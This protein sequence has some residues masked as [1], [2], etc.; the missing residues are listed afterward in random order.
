MAENYAISSGPFWVGTAMFII[1]GIIACF[2]TSRVFQPINGR[3]HQYLGLSW[4]MIS[5]T[6]FCCW[7]FWGMAW[8]MQW[9]PLITPMVDLTKETVSQ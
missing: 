6:T 9:H 2:I 7:M 1:L 3:S 4:V 5:M 8:L